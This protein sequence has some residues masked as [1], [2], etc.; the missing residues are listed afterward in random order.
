MTGTQK[1]TGKASGTL[2]NADQYLRI[3][4]APA[5]TAARRP[6]RAPQTRQ[7]LSSAGRPARADVHMLSPYAALDERRLAAAMGQD[8]RCGRARR[9][10]ATCGVRLHA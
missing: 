7:A 1:S 9:I 3:A 5:T 4:A 8:H 2:L 6:N 10:H